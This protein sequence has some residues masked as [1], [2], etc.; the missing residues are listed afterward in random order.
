[1][2]ALLVLFDGICSSHIESVSTS[3]V[4]SKVLGFDI[5]KPLAFMI[6]VL[7]RR[8]WLFIGDH[9]LLVVLFVYGIGGHAVL[10][11]IRELYV[12]VALGDA[13]S[14]IMEKD[15]KSVF[16]VQCTQFFIVGGAVRASQRDVAA[17]YQQREQ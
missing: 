5:D 11:M 16:K 9:A 14:G 4:V 17:L 12:V 1:M 2:L 7:M 13:K 15:A 8:M 3:C 10:E 6:E